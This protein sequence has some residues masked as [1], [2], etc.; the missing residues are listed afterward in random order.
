[1]LDPDRRPSEP[2][3]RDDLYHIQFPKAL[4]YAEQR[5]FDS[6][7]YPDAVLSLCSGAPE[8]S[9]KIVRDALYT[10]TAEDEASSY[11]DGVDGLTDEHCCHDNDSYGIADV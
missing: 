8:K 7:A 9:F 3:A 2:Y 5:F 10:F 4:P 11:R 6:K 1:M